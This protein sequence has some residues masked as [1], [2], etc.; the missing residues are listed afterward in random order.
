MQLQ[1][2]RAV[3][4][5]LLSETVWFARTADF[6]AGIAPVVARFAPAVAATE[7]VLAAAL[8]PRL[9]AEMGRNTDAF[10]SAGIPAGLARHIASQRIL[11]RAPDIALAAE[12]SGRDLAEAARVY[13]AIAEDFRIARLTDLAGQIAV[14]DYYDELALDRAVETL[15]VAQRRLAVAALKEGRGNG[16]LETWLATRQAAAK[17]VLAEVTA[18]T[19]AGA[20]TVSAVGVAAGLMADLAAQPA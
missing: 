17:R 3:Q 9:A 12:A 4:D 8:P 14:S 19:E 1:L 10:R 15:A 11:A 13:L 16:S 20:L 6:A 18:M 5:L 7:R 2:Y